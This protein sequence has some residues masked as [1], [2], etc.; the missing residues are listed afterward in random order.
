M[1]LRAKSHTDLQSAG[2]SDDSLSKSL[3][4]S[5]VGFGKG[6]A[7]EVRV[8]SRPTR[9]PLRVVRP[10]SAVSNNGSFLQINHLQGELVR[11]RK[12]CEDLRRENKL[13]SNEIR[14][15]RIAMRSENELMMRNLR[16]VNQELQAQVKDMK[17][18]LYQSQQ[19]A[20]LC[21]Q[22]VDEAEALRGEADKG[23]ALAEARALASQRDKEE[24]QDDRKRLREQVEQ[25]QKERCDL[26]LVL[27]QTEK[28]L[29]ETKLK[30]DR[31]SGE[32]QALQQDNK[33]LE[34][35][36]D[37]LRHKLR[38]TTE[39]NIQLK[40][41]EAE[42]K[43]RA[44]ACQEASE[45]AERGRQ[46][47][48]KERR[49]AEKERQERA[50]ECLN[51]KEKHLVLDHMVRAQ[52]DMKALRQDKSCQANIK[53]YFLC[54]TESDQRVKILKNQ[55][56]SPRNFMEGDPVYI[57]TPE[58][59]SEESERSSSRMMFRVSAPLS[60]RDSGPSHFD[61]L[62]PLEGGRPDSANHRRGRKVVDYF[63]IPTDQ[64]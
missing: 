6:T 3:S 48:E 11:K 8:L 43:C 2:S 42:W 35:D 49:L 44:T 16:N 19:R 10:V 5:R 30:L 32:K 25:L 39:E 7:E 58:C 36:R 28:N 56:G 63:W 22:A 1:A 15:E 21:S 4:L 64:D 34:Q 31:V 53:S 37:A 55:D 38:Q 27:A 50:A 59:N 33:G 26:Q 46:E 45:R 62:S 12:E 29:F 24:A 9:R 40:E 61:E 18:R 17:Q 47:A 57:S 51:W 14:M 54:M 20:T 41:S 60:V 13:L 52:E 23:R